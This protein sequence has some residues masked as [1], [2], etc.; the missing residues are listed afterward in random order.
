VAALLYRLGGFAYRRRALVL[1]VWIGVLVVLGVGAATVGGSTSTTFSIPGTESQ[2]AIDLLQ[3]RMPEASVGNASARIVFTASGSAQ[4]TDPA[5]VAAIHRVLRK[6]SA[7]PHVAAVTDPLVTKTISPDQRAMIATVLF[8]ISAHEVT[9]AQRAALEAA[10]R[11]AEPAGMQVEFGGSAM[12]DWTLSHT[13]EVVAVGIAA[14][15]LLVTFGSLVAAGMPLVTAGV[16]VGSSL[17]LI[18][19]ATRFF[20]LAWVTLVLALML[21]LAVGIDYSLFIVSRYRHELITGR[22]GEDAAGRA[23]ATAGSAVFFAGLTV[24]IALSALA[25]VGIPFMTTMGLAAAGAVLATVLIALTLLPAA[26][27]F[28]GERVLGRRGRAARDTEG[29]AGEPPLGERWGR[30]AIRFRIPVLVVTVA[31]LLVCALPARDLR[32]G[33]PND[34]NAPSGSTQRLAYEQIAKAFGPGLNGPLAVAVD[35]SHAADPRA[36][37]AAIQKDVGALPDV[38]YVAPATLN[39]TGD[40]AVL[41]VI[42]RSG[43]SDQATTDL[44][45]AIRGHSSGWQRAT[46]GRAFVT[47]ETAVAIDTS[48]KLQ[49][50]LIP[51]LVVIVGL[52][53]IL[54]AVVFR[55]LLIPLKAVVG[56]LLSVVATFGAVVA[57]FQWGWLQDLLGVS[58]PGPIIAFAPI[59]LIGILF[60][61]AMDYEVFLV[62]RIREEHMRGDTANDAI[63]I[64][65]RHGARVVVAAAIIMI[66]VFGGFV[67]QTD[68][69]IKTVGFAFAFGVFA[70]AFLV[71]MAFGPAV[72]SLLG[73]RAWRLP[74]WLDRTLPNVDVEGLSLPPSQDDRVG[75]WAQTQTAPDQVQPETV[76]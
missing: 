17:L 66:S 30:F 59:F 33:M 74:S 52:A 72:M 31:A 62:T 6:V 47:G 75:D 5:K 3:A 36:A 44:V 69:I 38:A 64:G 40:T 50:A 45:K 26:L 2:Q 73:G 48:A 39:R 71:R 55:S 22:S 13:S 20:D 58:S 19:I 41:N 63:A 35:L 65:F 25:V 14:V 21:G 23:V 49:G 15:V 70:D 68:P 42:P 46:G 32:L 12:S 37:A 8:D 51:Y 34:G 1:A 60:G 10:G 57:V 29:D 43:P 67:L 7:L 16:G 53:F 76:K 4:L 56:F 24:I 61:L 9:D 18:Q 54:L 28:V 27:G 11:T